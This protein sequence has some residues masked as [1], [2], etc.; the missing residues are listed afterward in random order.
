[1]SGGPGTN[2]EC[3]MDDL[4]EWV[5]FEARYEGQGRDRQACTKDRTFHANIA[6]NKNVLNQ[7]QVCYNHEIK[8]WTLWL[9]HSERK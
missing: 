2:L 5:S 3:H 6:A 1:M 7:R 4:F 8:R 9:V